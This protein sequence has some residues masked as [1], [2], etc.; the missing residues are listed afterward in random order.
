MSRLFSFIQIPCANPVILIIDIVGRNIDSQNKLESRQFPF[1]NIAAFSNR[2]INQ[3]VVLFCNT[4]N[5]SFFHVQIVKIAQSN[6]IVVFL[7]FIVIHVIAR[8]FIRDSLTT[9]HFLGN[10]IVNGLPIVV[11]NMVS[12]SIIFIAHFKIV[13]LVVSHAQRDP[14]LVFQIVTELNNHIFLKQFAHFGYHFAGSIY[15]INI[16]KTGGWVIRRTRFKRHRN[17]SF[18]VVIVGIHVFGNIVIQ[19][20]LEWIDNDMRFA[21]ESAHQNNGSVLLNRCPIRIYTIHKSVV[22]NFFPSLIVLICN[23]EINRVELGRF[24]LKR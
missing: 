11:G 21:I 18:F 4:S 7:R 9:Q 17:V 2:I 16:C 14:F 13:C 12:I 8:L 6:G 3:Y 22:N 24:P 23:Q 20:V 1:W 15:N 10:W 5:Q 19:H